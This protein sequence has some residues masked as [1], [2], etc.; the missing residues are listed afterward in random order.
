MSE[1][2]KSYNMQ[3]RLQSVCHLKIQNKVLN[4]V[5]IFIRSSSKIVAKPQNF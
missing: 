3:M 1:T 4:F 2:F 5:I